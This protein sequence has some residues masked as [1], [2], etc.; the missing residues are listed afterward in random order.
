MTFGQWI[1]LIFVGLFL[2]LMFGGLIVWVTQLIRGGRRY[3]QPN[4]KKR[5]RERR[6][7]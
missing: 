2:L 4:R 7:T 5:T 1:L 3:R 6:E